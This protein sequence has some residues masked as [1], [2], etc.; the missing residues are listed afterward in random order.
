M[1]AN[2]YNVACRACCDFVGGVQKIYIII[3]LL[4]GK[5]VTK[6]LKGLDSFIRSL[7]MYPVPRYFVIQFAFLICEGCIFSLQVASY[8]ITFVSQHKV[9]REN[10]VQNSTELD[11]FFSV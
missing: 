2:Y 10:L 4:L 7:N 9:P 3:K 5:D 8:L 1:F 11:N 6:D